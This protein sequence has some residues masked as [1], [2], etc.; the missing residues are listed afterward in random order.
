M[1]QIKFRA[2]DKRTKVIWY[3]VLLKFTVN[4]VF[5]CVEDKDLDSDEETK[6]FEQA[7]NVLMQFTGL[8]DKNGKEIYEG[9]MVINAD[10]DIEEY[11]K[12]KLRDCV[13]KMEMGWLWPGGLNEA[14]RLIIGNIYEDNNELPPQAS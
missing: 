9:D 4:G 8:L 6:V 12:E 1:R 13:V 5:P 2:W 11:D 10:I 3:P 7:S 14:S